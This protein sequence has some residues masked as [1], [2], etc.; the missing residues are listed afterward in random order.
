MYYAVI[1]GHPLAVLH[2]NAANQRHEI[3]VTEDQWAEVRKARLLQE[4]ANDPDLR[5]VEPYADLAADVLALNKPDPQPV[6]LTQE[7]AMAMTEKPINGWKLKGSE[8]GD[9][10]PHGLDQH[11]PGAKLDA[12]KI[13]AG[14][15]LGFSDALLAVAEVMTY[16]A[17]K[18]SAH[19]WKAVPN[20]EERYLDAGMRHL[21][22]QHY[23]PRDREST[24]LH[25]QHKAWNSLAELQLHIRP[26]SACPT[27]P[28]TPST[29]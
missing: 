5:P 6:A 22:Q 26:D 13:R 3:A 11:A 7:Q 2:G 20:G 24:L 27:P 18:Y 29:T 19:G 15:L 25:L 23:E 8:P 14:L 28:Q 10:D 12:G 1:L 16:G 9:S 21:L 4:F 17:E